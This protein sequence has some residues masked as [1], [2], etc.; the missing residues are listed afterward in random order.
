MDNEKRI[1]NIMKSLDGMQKATPSPYLYSKIQNRLQDSSIK[2]APIQWAFASISAL[3]L[4]LLINISLFNYS[5]KTK[6]ESEDTT[7]FISSQQE[8]NSD[9]LY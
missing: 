7:E 5:N 4:L 3:T 6:Q 2:N 1:S 9:Q 8:M